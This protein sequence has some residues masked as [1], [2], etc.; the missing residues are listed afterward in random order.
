[1]LAEGA[2][3]DGRCPIKVTYFLDTDPQVLSFASF[4]C[5][6]ISIQH[7]SS[8]LLWNCAETDRD[9]WPH[10][11]LARTARM[12]SEDENINSIDRSAY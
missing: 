4:E 12:T 11:H 10:F 1:M 5:E 9:Y 2:T 6:Q 3:L 8:C 7:E